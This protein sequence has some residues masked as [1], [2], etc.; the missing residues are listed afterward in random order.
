MSKLTRTGSFVGTPTYMSPEQ[1]RCEKPIDSRSDLYSIGVILYEMLTGKL[2]ITGEHLNAVVVN[3]LIEP[4]TPP[5]ESYA[6]FPME[7]E[8]LLMRLLSKDPDDRP[9]NARSIIE[10]IKKLT[11]YE[12]REEHLTHYTTSDTARSCALGDL[13]SNGGDTDESESGERKGARGILSEMSSK[14]TPADWSSSVAPHSRRKEI[15]IGS[16]IGAVAIAA[17]AFSFFFISVDTPSD[18]HPPPM[19]NGSP[20]SKGTAQ[21]NGHAQTSKPAYAEIS[22][23]N[24]PEGAAIFFDGKPQQS[25]RFEVP[26][27]KV[28]KTLRITAEGH[29]DYIRQ[30]VPQKRM[31]IKA[32]MP[33]VPVTSANAET[34]EQAA[35]AETPDAVETAKTAE[36]SASAKTSP[37][38]ATVPPSEQLSKRVAYK[39]ETTVLSS[40]APSKSEAKTEEKKKKRSSRFAK[41]RDG[42][43]AV[44]SFE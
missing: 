14:P 3:V 2:P 5:K 27:S 15:F 16:V 23:T 21:K 44:S 28:E 7:A 22:I 20:V 34:P 35:A 9:N 26:I 39:K 8:P 32:D 41:T 1:I 43:K 24:V 25:S 42:K 18:R 36:I 38:V 11:S 6:D 19:S 4:P 30:V 33:S 37:P 10:E 17:A 29:Q 31:E 12:S 40:S 13:G